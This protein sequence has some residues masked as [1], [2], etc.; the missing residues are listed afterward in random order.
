LTVKATKAKVDLLQTSRR[1]LTASL[2]EKRRS[3]QSNNNRA[4]STE[5][6]LQSVRNLR[7]SELRAIFAK[8]AQNFKSLSVKHGLNR[9][10]KE[11]K[12]K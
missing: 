3:N 2:F 9:V 8:S 7:E 10:A 6:A 12:L 4:S 1:K 5:K 11:S